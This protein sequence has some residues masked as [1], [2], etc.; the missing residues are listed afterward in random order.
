M[1]MA[2][3]ATAA[4]TDTVTFLAFDQALTA[5]K[6]LIYTPSINLSMLRFLNMKKE[7]NSY[8]FDSQ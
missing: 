2:A 7:Q 8:Q 3:T 5:L 1:P 6:M 4:M